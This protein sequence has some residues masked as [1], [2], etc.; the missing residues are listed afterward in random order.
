MQ[1]R[2]KPGISGS[3]EG[4]EFDE[5]AGRIVGA[6]TEAVQ[7][8]GFHFRDIDRSG[9]LACAARGKVCSGQARHRLGFV[10]QSRFQA[11]Q[12]GQSG[13]AR[14]QILKAGQA[15]LVHS[16]RSSHKHLSQRF[17]S[18]TSTLHPHY[19]KCSG[20]NL[21]KKFRW[22]FAVPEVEQPRCCSLPASSGCILKLM[23]AAA[24][25]LHHEPPFS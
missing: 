11:G 12:R 13:K 15:G 18:S 16:S 17:R 21:E 9:E 6:Y 23:D 14:S 19:N 8:F 7:V 1:D 24:L 2:R 10:P 5:E 3:F 20:Q 4:G 25:W 22:D